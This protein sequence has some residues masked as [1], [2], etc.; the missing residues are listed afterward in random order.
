MY[1][2]RVLA[3]TAIGYVGVSYALALVLSVV[4][5]CYVVGL[6]GGI[7]SGKS[8]VT[9]YLTQKRKVTVIDFGMS[10]TYHIRTCALRSLYCAL[11]C[12]MLLRRWCMCACVCACSRRR[13]GS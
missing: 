5:G 10:H 6:T 1:A 12:L 11:V 4:F 13:D 3:V 2:L 9:K 8:T 7:A